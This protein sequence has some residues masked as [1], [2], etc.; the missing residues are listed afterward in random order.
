MIRM[1]TDEEVNELLTTMQHDEY[2]RGYN[3]R[4]RHVERAIAEIQREISFY[5]TAYSEESKIT[6]SL[7]RGAYRKAIDIIKKNV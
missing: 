7:I 2:L 3:A 5:D 4:K 6:Y 1:L